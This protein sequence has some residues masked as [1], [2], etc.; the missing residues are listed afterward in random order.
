MEIEEI[1]GIHQNKPTHNLI[2]QNRR[3]IISIEDGLIYL[4][5]FSE[6]VLKDLRPDI[7]DQIINGQT[8]LQ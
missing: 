4:K 7:P 1:S 2:E 8:V 3:V 6:A 5:N